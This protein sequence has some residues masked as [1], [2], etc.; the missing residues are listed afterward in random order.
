M[1]YQPGYGD[2][3]ARVRD[4]S[5][6]GDYPEPAAA[7]YPKPENRHQQ[8]SSLIIQKQTTSL[9]IFDR[10]AVLRLVRGASLFWLVE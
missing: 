1:E 3:H 10:V 8:L 5:D 9:D 2:K 6:G 4:E 7:G